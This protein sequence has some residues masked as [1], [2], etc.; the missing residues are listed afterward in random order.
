MQARDHGED[1]K[2][3]TAREVRIVRVI[4]TPLDDSKKEKNH[5]CTLAPSTMTFMICSLGVSTFRRE[6]QKEG[7]E[8]HSSPLI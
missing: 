2:G 1:V 4:Q 6:G 8:G 7:T 5:P 3:L